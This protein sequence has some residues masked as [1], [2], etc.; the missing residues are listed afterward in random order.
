MSYRKTA[1]HLPHQK[2]NLK[3]IKHLRKIL[4]ECVIISST[5]EREYNT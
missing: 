3:L 5:A 2:K 1:M 4:H